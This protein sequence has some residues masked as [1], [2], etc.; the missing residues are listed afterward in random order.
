M[1]EWR[2]IIKRCT[3]SPLTRARGGNLRREEEAGSYSIA[4]ADMSV[5]ME[6]KDEMKSKFIHS[7]QLLLSHGENILYGR[8]LFATIFVHCLMR[9]F[10]LAL[11]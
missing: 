8:N 11:N 10:F 1:K 7:L 4:E 9:F 5:W 2:E 3:L 6:K